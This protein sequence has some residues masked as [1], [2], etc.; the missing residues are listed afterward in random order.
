MQ[1]IFMAGAHIYL[2]IKTFNVLGYFSDGLGGISESHPELNPPEDLLLAGK[3]P[4]LEIS[5]RTAHEAV[6]GLLRE[7]APR[8][9]TYIAIGPLTNLAQTLR[10]DG[11]CVRERIG[12]VVIMGGALDVPGNASPSAECACHPFSMLAVW[13]MSHPFTLSQFLCGSIR[14]GRGADIADHLLATGARASSPTRYYLQPHAPLLQLHCAC[15][16]CFCNRRTVHTYG[17]DTSHTLY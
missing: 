15:R 3:H 11:A 13:L 12:R 7:Y 5:D 10:T 8:S 6:L 1:T 16:P 17:Q 4:Y 2:P 14:S 9:V